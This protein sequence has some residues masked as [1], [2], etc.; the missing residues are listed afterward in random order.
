MASPRSTG[1][2]QAKFMRRISWAS[3]APVASPSGLLEALDDDDLLILICSS[4]SAKELGRMVCTSSRFDKPALVASDPST[5]S[6][7]TDGSAA[8]ETQQVE[9]LS[10][11]QE[12]ARRWLANCTTQ[13]RAWAPGGGGASWLDRMRHV[14]RLRRPPAFTLMDDGAGLLSEQ[15]AQLHVPSTACSVAVQSIMK[16]CLIM[17]LVV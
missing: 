3:G 7:A 15:G 12:S 9:K 1:W 11:V 5:S 16:R 10:I 14:E 4:L 8:A 6:R 17:S 2:S 13:E